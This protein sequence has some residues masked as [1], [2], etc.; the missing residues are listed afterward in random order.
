MTD[1]S[2]LAFIRRA[3]LDAFWSKAPDTVRGLRSLFWEQV[4]VGDVFGF[5]MFQ[6]MGPYGAFYDSGIRTALGVLWRSQKPGRHEEKQKYSSARK[7]WTV[8]TDVYRASAR[9]IEGTLVWRSERGRFVATTAPS[10]SEWFASFMSGFRS[11][12]GERRKQD[13]AISIEVMLEIQALF[14]EDWEEVRDRGIQQQREVAEA[15]VFMIVGYVASL[16]G[17]E[18]PKT[19]LTDLRRQVFLTADP[20]LPDMPPHIGW[21]L[22]GRFKAR[23]RAIQELLVFVA[24]ETASGLKPGLWT[25]RLLSVLDQLDVRHG[26]LFQDQHGNARRMMTFAPAFYE[27]LL[28]VRDRKPSLFPEGINILEDYHLARSMRRGA[29]TRATNAGVSKE[30]IEWINRW[31]TGGEELSSG[32]MRVTYADRRQLLETYLRFSLA[33]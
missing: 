24:A 32:P 10:D 28:Q 3:N 26:W 11:R 12:V 33:L 18:L 23:S 31:S 29:T 2:L 8:H 4:E 22:R 6:P 15:A 5:Q 21:P 17:F 1:D 13:A 14:E 25:S 16:R 9:A 19:V 7:A 30:D 27:K 20:A